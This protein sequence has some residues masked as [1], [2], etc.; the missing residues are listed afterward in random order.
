MELTKD[1]AYRELQQILKDKVLLVV[2]TGASMGLDTR[3]GIGALK[4]ELCHKIPDKISHDK[5]AA[6]QWKKVLERLNSNGDLEGALNVEEP[7]LLKKIVLV[8]GNFVAS[9]DKENKLKILNNEAEIPIGH[10]LK[11]LYD[12]M[13]SFDPA[14]DIIT[15]NYDLLLEHCCDSL[16]IP[17]INGFYGGIRKQ[18]DWNESSQQVVYIQDIPRGKR[19]L[20]V[21]RTKK[22]VRIHKVHG[23][24]NWFSRGEKIFE[25][26]S[27]VYNY[28]DDNPEIERLIITP[29]KDKYH[30]VFLKT[31]DFFFKA[32]PAITDA[33]AFV[34]IGY[35]FNDDHIQQKIERHIL[36][37]EKPGIIITKVLPKNSEELLNKSDKLW[38]VYQK[39]NENDPNETNT[40]I[41]N[42][43]YGTPLILENSSTW[44]I[45]HFSRDV[46]GA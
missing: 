12:G 19:F 22:H 27:L 18:Y 7:S 37:K 1:S 43:A 9:I 44:E 14:L 26:N 38:A 6:K 5:I 35:G 24:I 31:S 28:Q 25:D 20:K 11:R 42:R 8:T 33:N 21:E 46:L 29:G 16:E 36:E 40:Y 32:D 39:K 17:Y 34:F 23:S 15:P 4:E 45:Q 2:G 41:R 10:F 3:F 30:Q 13:A